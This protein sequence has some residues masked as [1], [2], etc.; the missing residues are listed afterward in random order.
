MMEVP[1][2]L[3]PAKGLVNGLILGALAWAV[4]VAL[5]LMI[6]TVCFGEDNPPI[7]PLSREGNSD[8]WTKTDTAR[9][10]V[11]MILHAVDWGQTLEIA[12]H[13]DD[14]RE[15]N[16]ILGTHPTVGRV[17]L[18]MGAWALAHPAISYLL[19]GDWRKTWQYLTIGVS[20]TSTANNFNLGLRVKI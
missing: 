20:F 13:P 8:D 12:R 5:I 1:E 3:R 7:P 14:F 15:M 2:A 16:P 17:N 9:E 19:P 10:V 18:Y 4:I 6:A 11:W